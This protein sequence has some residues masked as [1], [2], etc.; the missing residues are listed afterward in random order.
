MGLTLRAS[1]GRVL[2]MYICIAL[3]LGSLLALGLL[4]LNFRTQAASAKVTPLV[5]RIDEVG[6]AEAVQTSTAEPSSIPPQNGAGTS[7]T[8]FDRAARPLGRPSTREPSRAGSATAQS[9][10]WSA[11]CRS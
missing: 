5:V 3:A 2:N 1:L 8:A 10:R 11:T 7:C 9:G 6:R 4:V